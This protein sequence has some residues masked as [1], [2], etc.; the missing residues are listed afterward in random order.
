MFVILIS[1]WYDFF[2]IIFQNA[3][4]L[5]FPHNLISIPNLRDQ[6]SLIKKNHI[7]TN[8]ETKFSGFRNFGITPFA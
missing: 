1:E 8:P 5:T 7:L 2:N 6:Q 3:Y 4:I